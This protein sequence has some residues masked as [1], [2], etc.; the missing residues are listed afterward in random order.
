MT[1]AALRALFRRQ[2]AAF[3]KR[4][5][6]LAT[7]RLFVVDRTCPSGHRCAPRDLAWYADGDVHI[8]RRALRRSRD[9]VAALLAHELGHAADV[10]RWRPGSEQRADDIAEAVLGR[11]IHYNRRTYV[12]TFGPGLYPRPLDLHT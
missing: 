12:Q 6:R 11:R 5:P 1:L 8:L 10:R 2:R 9:T 7:V 3:A 4:Y